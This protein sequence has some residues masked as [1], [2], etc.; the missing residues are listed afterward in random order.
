MTEWN[1]TAY[2]RFEADRTRPA[3]DLLARVPK[4]PRSRIFDL[5]CG[6]GASTQV[7]A[8]CYPEATIVG[9]D[10][11]PEML[12]A[13]RRRLTQV[14]FLEADAATWRGGPADLIVANA[15]L[16]WVPGHL[17][18]MRELVRQLA[19]HGCLAVQMPDNENEPTHALMRE[20][21]SRPQ[22]LDKLARAG[23]ARDA[24]G[25]FQDYDDALSP[26]CD[27][28]DIWRTVYVHRLE[29]PEAIVAWVESTGL[30]PFL[31]PLDEAERAEFL[32]LY[33]EGIARAYPSRPS[34]GVLL[35][36]P[37]IFVVASRGEAAAS[38]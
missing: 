26:I 13:A 34:G 19:S 36:F 14:A 22:F 12:A 37:R 5:G 3:E 31:A 35:P 32:A 4:R 29:G 1:P 15:V 27:A 23:D 8:E 18:V 20:I 7:V 9:L 21:A 16:H 38:D 10:T 17:Q 24:I 28:V 25:S 33:R 6:A 11:S 30:R 2:R